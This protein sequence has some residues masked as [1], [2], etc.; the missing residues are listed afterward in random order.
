MEYKYLYHS[1]SFLHMNNKN[2]STVINLAIITSC[3]C[4][5]KDLFPIISEVAFLFFHMQLI[6]LQTA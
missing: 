4:I 1:Y 5:E 3:N 6:F 2:E